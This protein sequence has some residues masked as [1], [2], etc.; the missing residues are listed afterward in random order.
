MGL[1]HIVVAAA[2]SSIYNLLD[3]VCQRRPEAVQQST[4]S[5]ADFLNSLGLAFANVGRC[6]IAS[7]ARQTSF[8]TEK[9]LME[10]LV[11]DPFSFSGYCVATFVSWDTHWC[12]IT[13]MTCSDSF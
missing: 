12:G 9:T 7:N 11:L 13:F 3:L 6:R 5:A 1:I 2:H 8:G 4:P 10:S